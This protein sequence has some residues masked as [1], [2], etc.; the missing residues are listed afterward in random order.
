MPVLARNHRQILSALGTQGEIKTYLIEGGKSL[1]IIVSKFSMRVWYVRD[2][3]V[4]ADGPIGAAHPRAC[5][6]SSTTARKAVA[7]LTWSTTA[8]PTPTRSATNAS[9]SAVAFPV[10]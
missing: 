9:P 7:S 8:T 2:Q 1:V 4:A 5:L 3:M 6:S 10:D